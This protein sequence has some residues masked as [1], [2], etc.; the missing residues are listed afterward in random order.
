LQV[1]IVVVVVKGTL[2]P[3]VTDNCYQTL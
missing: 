2:P 3:E 1:S